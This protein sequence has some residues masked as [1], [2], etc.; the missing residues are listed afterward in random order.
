MCVEQQIRSEIK[1]LR[2]F[3]ISVDSNVFWSDLKEMQI[4]IEIDI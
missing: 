1:K 4:A 3:T 2:V